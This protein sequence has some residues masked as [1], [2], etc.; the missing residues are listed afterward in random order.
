MQMCTK[1]LSKNT[2]QTPVVQHKPYLY[3]NDMCNHL[4]FTN[5]QQTCTHSRLCAPRKSGKLNWNE[6]YKN[7]QNL[8]I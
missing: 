7:K 6:F 3:R 4:T 2:M 1:Y 8:K 5:T